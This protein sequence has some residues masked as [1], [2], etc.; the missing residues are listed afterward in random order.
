MVILIL[1]ALLLVLQSLLTVTGLIAR[2]VSG[3]LG[4]ILLY[5]LAMRL[6][7]G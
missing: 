7:I 6:L 3:I 4:L 1:L 2:L 5:I